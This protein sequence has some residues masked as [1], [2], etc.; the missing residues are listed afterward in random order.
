VW[1]VPN[2]QDRLR[3]TYANV[4]GI[5]FAM[6]VDST[7]AGA[8]IAAFPIDYDKA[9][10]LLPPGDVH[11]FRIWKKAL[12]LVTVVDYR[13]TDIGNYIEY[14][15]AIAVTNGARPAPPL[16]PAIFQR[17][18]GTG[19][20]V[21][22]LPVSTEISVKGGKGIWGMPKH[23]ASLDY[24]TGQQWVS[25]QY[26]LD[27]QMV[28]R[29]DVR[30]PRSIWAPVSMPAVN[31]CMFRGMIMRSLIHFK[32]KAGVHLFRG[33]AARITLGSHPRSQWL[34]RLMPGKPIFA[35]FLPSV[36]GLLD[37]RC[38]TWFAA[39]A[40]PPAGPIGEGLETTYPLAYGKTWLEPPARDASFDLDKE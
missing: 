25:A 7:D 12:L 16:L 3:G 6:P 29:F 5:P 22:D 21:V 15:L 39:Y 34:A 26:D 36:N 40:E 30:R 38:E 31:Y 19:Q 9:R 10:E 17:W 8:V 27:G 1:G 37:D 13:K 4:D 14:S 20:Y 23:Q 24:K 35:A 33:D 2:R 18:F 28:M 32:G 11:P